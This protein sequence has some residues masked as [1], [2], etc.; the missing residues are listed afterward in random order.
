MKCIKAIVSGVVQGVNYRYFCYQKA[1]EMNIKGY[2]KNL[3]NGNVE[4]I[5]NGEDGLI[6]DFIK[7]LK[8]GPKASKVNSVQVEE[9][10]LCEEYNDFSVY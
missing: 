4:V 6:I 10:D 1:T 9:L 7:L 5:A 3:Y 8:V 2:A